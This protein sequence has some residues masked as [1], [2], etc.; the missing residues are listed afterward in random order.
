MSGKKL[1]EV[2]SYIL[3]VDVRAAVD[4]F[5]LLSAVGQGSLG[6]I[7][8]VVEP[9]TKVFVLHLG[10]GQNCFNVEVLQHAVQHL[11]RIRDV[12]DTG[13]DAPPAALILTASGAFFSNG[14]HLAALTESGEQLLRALSKLYLCLLTYPIPTVAAINGHAFAG[15]AIISIACDYRLMSGGFFCVNELNIPM[16]FTDGLVAILKCKVSK[17]TLKGAILQGKR[18]T[19]HEAWNAGLVDDVCA[20]E[21]DLKAKAFALCVSEAPKGDGV[22]RDYYRSTKHQMYQSAID[23]LQPNASLG[24][25]I[26]EFFSRSKM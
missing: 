26:D 5:L 15:G 22:A 25:M 9:G 3:N 12:R 2:T 17:A 20:N 1:C 21:K 6:K 19:S 16:P 10:S 24:S 14:L 4:R 13:G 18:Y 8:P 7:K 11:E 23:K